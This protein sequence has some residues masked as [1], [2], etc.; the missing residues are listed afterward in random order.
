MQISDSSELAVA[1]QSAKRSCV[2][3][4]LNSNG[5]FTNSDVHYIDS[6][7][8]RDSLVKIP[9]IHYGQES[10]F[11]D[12][13][14]IPILFFSLNYRHPILVDK[15]YSAK[16]LSD[17]VVIVQNSQRSFPTRLQCNSKSTFLN[18]RNPIK[19]ALSATSVLAGGIIPSHITYSEA[20]QN[21]VADWTWSVGDHP[22]SHT[23]N[24]F[25]FNHIQIDIAKRNMILNALGSSIDTINSAVKILNRIRIDESNER[26]S[27]LIPLNQLSLSFQHIFNIWKLAVSKIASLDFETALKQIRAAD[28]KADEFFFLALESEAIMKAYQCLPHIIEE[29]DTD[30]Q[31]VLLLPILFICFDILLFVIIFMYK[32][33]KKTNKSQN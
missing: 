3:P 9:E 22:W 25:H 31:V 27:H 28:A 29:N 4:Y 19:H 17:M 24:G 2:L 11:S 26:V 10:S 30:S 33:G 5:I 15:Y 8:L 16:G 21:A 32:R 6:V 12:S 18:L 7:V 14:H 23:S 1:F 20:H 13:R